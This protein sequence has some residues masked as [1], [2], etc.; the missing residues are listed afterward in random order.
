MSTFDALPGNLQVHV[1]LQLTNA[2]DSTNAAMACKQWLELSKEVWAMRLKE[3]VAAEGIAWKPSLALEIQ[4]CENE[5]LPEDQ[6]DDHM[7]RVRALPFVMGLGAAPTAA[8]WARTKPTVRGGEQVFLNDDGTEIEGQWGCNE[9]VCDYSCDSNWNRGFCWGVMSFQPDKQN[10]VAFYIVPD[11][12]NSP[13]DPL[14]LVSQYPI[15]FNGGHGAWEFLGNHVAIY[16]SPFFDPD[17]IQ[18]YCI[19]GR[20]L[21]MSPGSSEESVMRSLGFCRNPAVEDD[22]YAHEARWCRLPNVDQ[23]ANEAPNRLEERVHIAEIREQVDSDSDS[24]S[25]ADDETPD[26][27]A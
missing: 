23:Y 5:E 27:A 4:C 22:D 25:D 16:S 15:T 13:I 10:E 18:A 12:P 24:K 1:L 20:L 17:V 21:R 2:R 6:I 7:R 3:C 11:L 14:A 8:M 26:E 9:S 19:G